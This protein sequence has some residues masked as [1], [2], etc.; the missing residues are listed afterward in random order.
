VF[1]AAPGDD[2]PDVALAKLAAMRIGIVATVGIDDLGL[3]KRS[4]ACSSNRRDSVDQ[5]QQL[6]DVVAV[7]ASQDRADRNAVHVDED[8]VSGHRSRAI[9][10][11]RPSFWPAPTARTDDES[12]A[13]YER[14]SWPDSWSLSSSTLNN[15]NGII[16]RDTRYPGQSS[17]YRGFSGN[18]GAVQPD[19]DESPL[20]ALPGRPVGA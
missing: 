14:S 13:A 2:G 20:P 11:V 9:R 15:R 16:C 7:R 8:V 1:G 10:G 12:T 4:A 17:D 3:A 18:G 19:T 6:G 5:R